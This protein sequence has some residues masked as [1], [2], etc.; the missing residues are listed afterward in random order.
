[1]KN[2]ERGKISSRCRESSRITAQEIFS[3]VRDLFVDNSSC[4]VDRYKIIAFKE[5]VELP[6]EIIDNF[7]TPIIKSIA[8][9]KREI[10]SRPAERELVRRKDGKL[11]WFY[12]MVKGDTKHKSKGKKK[13]VKKN[14]NK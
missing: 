3:V 1:M 10:S 8:D 13:K 9:L 2:V 4:V 12:D 5:S 6:P 14:K 11:V 7:L